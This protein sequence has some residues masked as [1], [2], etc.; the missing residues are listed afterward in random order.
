M[1]RPLRPPSPRAHL[2]GT[3]RL[4]R[5]LSRLAEPHPQAPAVFAFLDR[6][7]ALPA[8][9]P[10]DQVGLKY[11][12]YLTTTPRGVAWGVAV[13]DRY[14][15]AAMLPEVHRMV[16]TFG[17]RYDL[18][19][20]L[21]LRDQLDGPADVVVA[22]GFDAPDQ[23]PRVKLYLQED[24]WNTGLGTGAVLLAW[25]RSVVPDAQL[26]GWALQRTI[27]VAAVTLHH[28]GARD[29]KLYFGGPTPAAAS[30]GAPAPAP[31]L[32]AAMTHACPQAGGWYYL[33]LRIAPDRPHRYAMNKIYNA[34]QQGF[35][36][37]HSQ[38]MAAWR[39]VERLFE[40][41]GT[42]PTLDRLYAQLRGSGIF[43]LPTATA[44]EGQAPGTETDV[45]LAAWDRSEP[46]GPASR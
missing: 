27:G 6:P 4:L 40:H 46:M 15:G 12:A 14:E 25:I 16:D 43:A 29:L 36:V 1:P 9:V 41:A 45:Y 21:A 32:A 3:L 7:G 8:E 17:G 28:S 35:T 38:S 20:A 10:R 19:R 11:D 18:A 26:P 30:V 24:P 31:S 23:P 37:G 34:I 39:D 13:S 22:V 44:L 42:K 5:H 33:T 2:R